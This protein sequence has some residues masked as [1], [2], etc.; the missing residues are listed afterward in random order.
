MA[1][2]SRTRHA[3]DDAARSTTRHECVW[4]RLRGHGPALSVVAQ[5]LQVP[6]T[7]LASAVLTEWLEARCVAGLEQAA[8]DDAALSDDAITR[9]SVRMPT[10]HAAELACAARTAA[11]TRGNYVARLI[12]GV[13][14]ASVTPDQRENRLA[15]VRSTAE[16]AARSGDLHALMRAMRQTSSPEKAAC[17]AAVAELSNSLNRHL[18]V[19]AQLMV[20]LTPSQRQIA[21]DLVSR[22]QGGLT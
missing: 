22:R 18:A 16:L 13:P 11:L 15:L 5:S 6:L 14:A 3:A 9:V 10:R 20:S 17:D 4:V 12:E 7:T 19:A 1:K 8:G 21:A 2:V